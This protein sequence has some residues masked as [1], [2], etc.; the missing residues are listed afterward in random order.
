[1]E[2]LDWQNKSCWDCEHMNPEV[3]EPSEFYCDKLNALFDKAAEDDA[4]SD[5][6]SDV[7]YNG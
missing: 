1:M 5:F 4:C 6:V 3:D 2:K 7:I